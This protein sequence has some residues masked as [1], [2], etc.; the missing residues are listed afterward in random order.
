MF[1]LNLRSS[2]LVKNA[3]QL[4]EPTV[5]QQGA[6]LQTSNKLICNID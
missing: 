2:L 6:K 3:R 4:N 1:A 5:L